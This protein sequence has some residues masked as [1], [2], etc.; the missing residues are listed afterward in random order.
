[1]HNEVNAI[2]RL[3]RNELWSQQNSS[4]ANTLKGNIMPI[5]FQSLWE[6]YGDNTVDCRT[7]LHYYKKFRKDRNIADEQYSGWPSTAINNIS[8]TVHDDYGDW[9]RPYITVTKIEN[10]TR[11]PKL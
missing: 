10:E 1:M 2:R 9:W 5:I 3:V 8:K 6:V 11:I 7:I 4:N